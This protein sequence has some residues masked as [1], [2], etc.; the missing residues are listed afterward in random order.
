M[1]NWR[2]YWSKTSQENRRSSIAKDELALLAE[3]LEFFVPKLTE[4]M[5][6]AHWLLYIIIWS[7]F[8][9]VLGRYY[10]MSWSQFFGGFLSHTLNNILTV[11]PALYLIDYLRPV[12]KRLNPIRVSLYIVLIFSV[13]ALTSILLVMLA[14]INM[15]WL[16]YHEQKFILTIFFRITTVSVVILTFLLYFLRQYRQFILLKQSFEDTLSAQN[17]TIKAR[18]SPHFFF[19]TVNNLLALIEANPAR[20]SELLQ[21]ISALFRA[22]FNGAREISFEEEVAL[23]QH[24]IAIELSRLAGKLVVNWQLPEEDVMYDM[25]ITSLTLQSVLE[26]ILLNVVEMTT[27]TVTIDINVSWQQ[28]RVHI[29]I[30]VDLP[31][32]TLMVIHDLR[33]HINF[34]VQVERLRAYFGKSASIKSTVTD[35]QVV[36]IIDYELQDVAL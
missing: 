20:A 24:Y 25:V 15:G 27:E 1:K 12:F 7:L 19:N 35:K 11:F 13:S 3:R 16:E 22:S 33:R 29:I 18:I 23:C 6:P 21:H 26:K 14:M 34:E 28:H 36:T 9:T 10:F 5:K 30:T 8:V 17:D 4:M 31:S 32:K 2:S